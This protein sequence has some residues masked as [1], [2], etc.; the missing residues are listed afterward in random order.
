M[1]VF[2]FV[3]IILQ[4]WY[5][6]YY[7]SKLFPDKNQLFN[8]INFINNSLNQGL[9]KSSI[10]DSLKE[11]DWSDEQL[12][13]AWNKFN[14]KR[15]GMWEIPIFKWVENKKVKKELAKRQNIPVQSS[16]K[17]Q[18]R[19]PSRIRRNIKREIKRPPT[20]IRKQGGN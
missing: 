20:R 10:F 2:F 12:K 19:A 9:K 17:I 5:K 11:L 15:T 18:K 1:F 13:Y 4:E 3:Y 8:L 16:R 6:K 14:G 7:E